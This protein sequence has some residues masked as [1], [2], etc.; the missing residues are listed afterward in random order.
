MVDR[1]VRLVKV[2]HCV[3]VRGQV[4]KVFVSEHVF[5]LN[6]VP[7]LTSRFLYFGEFSLWVNA[8]SAYITIFRDISSCYSAWLAL[9][10]WI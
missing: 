8:E 2:H 5:L 9:N 7:E 3:M 6:F 1:C 10:S 4:V